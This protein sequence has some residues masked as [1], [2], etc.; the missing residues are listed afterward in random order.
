MRIRGRS[1]GDGMMMARIAAGLL[2]LA[3]VAG[4]GAAQTVMSAEAALSACGA[5]A[6][7]GDPG[8]AGTAAEDALAVARR[9]E[10]ERPADALEVRARVLIQCRIPFA[11]FLRRGELLEAANRLL[12]EALAR[13]PAHLGA[14][15]ALAMNHYHSPPFLGRTDDAIREFER[16][17]ADHDG[18]GDPRVAASRGYLAELYERTGRSAEGPDARAAEGEE[19]AG[20]APAPALPGYTLDP[21]VVE[22]G[23][24]SMEDPRTATRLS[25]TEV[26]TMP[27][28]TADVLQVFQT[29]PGVTQVTD[30]SDLYVRGGDPAETPVYVDG[31]RLFYPGRFETLN[32]SLFGVLD[33]S[34][35]R[36]AYFS[37]G[38]FSARYGNALSGVVE[39]ETD[40]RPVQPRWRAGLNLATLG[41]S[42]WRPA[43]DRAGIWGTA[44]VT[45]TD[46][47][48]RLHGRSDDY[49]TSP[50]SLQ[51]MI[52]LAAEPRDG[53]DLRVTA[54][55]EADRTVARVSSHGHDGPFRSRAAT[56]LATAQARALS[57]DGRRGLR[58]S[59][60]A[61]MRDS[62][63]RFGVL[64]RDREDRGAG[65]RLDGDMD[66]GRVHLRGG[67]EGARLASVVSGV[68]PAGPAV[69][70]GSPVTV[71]DRDETEA[72][73]LGG[74]GE[75]E[76]RVAQRLAMIAGLR[77]DALPGEDGLSVDPRLAAA[78]RL[79]EWT[80]RAGAGLYS[81][82][83]W[84]IRSDVPDAGRPSGVPLRARHLAAGVQ[85]DG[86]VAFRAEAYLKEYDD[87]VGD[88]D[89]PALTE[90]RAAGLD[91]LV[92]WSGAGRVNGWLTYS[93]LDGELELA[94]GGRVPSAYDVT[95]TAAAVARI[96]VGAAW[97]LGFT[98]RYATGRPFTP[99]TGAES[100]PEGTAAPI[101]GRVHSERLPDYVRLDGRLTRVVPLSGGVL[102][103]YLEGLN[104][105]DRR[106]VMAY[107]YDADYR[108]RHPVDSFFAK[109]TLV[110]GMEA[111]F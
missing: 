57:R 43:G 71:L 24:Y 9:I 58:L 41:G 29:L 98:G 16:L 91:V 72:H 102:V 49:P 68:V 33:P 85:R 18:S 45:R 61:S 76:A 19:A 89:G 111:Q 107:T 40:G 34:V 80:L 31:A 27:G 62:G 83:R 55:A 94:D 20:G 7:A 67:L 64:D 110:L 82:G 50:R 73:H 88:G 63:F 39:L 46:A 38:G 21:I 37:S 103:G 79:D 42:L 4:S 2:G 53:L 28:G 77:V 25:R 6:R 1:G 93:L 56:R 12:R 14:R 106:N 109:R 75:V 99:I 104:L 22:A 47:L 26:Y 78:Y 66:R 97:E 52:G 100:T 13:D 90:G 69:A 17:L 108:N 65:V 5:A 84:R 81:Q 10:A 32:G 96:A 101:Y 30:G 87:Y 60:S 51:G 3:M 48:L 95:H 23:G 74:Y 105:L 36:R 59:L 11:P 92:R 44:A 35:M 70:P 8:A 54:L 86:P 15:F